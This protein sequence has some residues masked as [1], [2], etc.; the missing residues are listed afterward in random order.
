MTPEDQIE[1][2]RRAKAA[3]A[4]LDDAF[5]AVSEG[6]LTRLRQIAVAEP[7]A[8]DKLR[9]L[10][11][12]QQIAEG[13]RNHIKAIAAGANVGEAELEYRRKIERMSPERR[14]ALGIAL[15]TDLWRG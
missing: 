6:Y 15:P 14:R 5:D 2:G 1:A 12:A 7:W 11:L 13:V 10:A 3:L 8:A 4:V 9:S